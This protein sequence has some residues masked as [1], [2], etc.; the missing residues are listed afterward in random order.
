MNQTK[1][2]KDLG[3]KICTNELVLWEKVAKEA[4]VLIE[5]SQDNLIIQEAILAL[6]VGKILHEKEKA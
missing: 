3:I 6:A 1:E 2:P 5:Q 4:R